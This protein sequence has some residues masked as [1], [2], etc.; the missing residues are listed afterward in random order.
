VK[1]SIRLGVLDQSPVPE[2]ATAGDALR[3]TIDLARLA[4]EIGYERYWIAEHHASPGLASASPEVLIGPVTAAT[5]RIRVGSGGVMLPHYSPLKVAESFAMLA[6]LFPGR[7]DLGLGR[8]PGGDAATALAL[9]RDRRRP[10]PDDFP[11]QLDELLGYFGE[12]SP[13]RRLVPRLSFPAPPEG[14]EPWLLGSSPDSAYWAAERGL[15]YCFADFINPGGARIAAVYRER[16]VAGNRL[17][18]PRLA[19]AGWVV[20]AETN[21]EAEELTAS[22]RMMMTLLYRGRLV[23]VP[24]VETALRFLANER[25]PVPH[26]RIIAGT[27]ATVR[28]GVESLAAEYGADEVLLVNILYDHAARRRS[29]ELVAEAFGLERAEEAEPIGTA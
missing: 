3:N 25:S 13:G 10:S 16:F 26:R 1:S 2:G 14:P 17:A 24:P 4:D 29:Y 12:P 21:A 5:H 27:P 11:E 19:V 6:G 18:A 9:Q 23:Q 20:C 28:E 22:F 15:P 7:I 8:A